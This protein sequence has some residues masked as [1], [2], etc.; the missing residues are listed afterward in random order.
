MKA[1]TRF[2]AALA[3]VCLPAALLATFWGALPTIPAAR[4]QE[5]KTSALSVLDALPAETTLVL[6]LRN[7]GDLK[8]K[9][10]ASPLNTVKEHPDVKRFLDDLR[11]KLEEGLAEARAKLGFDPLDLADLVQGEVILALGGLDKIAST[12][13]AE[14]SG[15]QSDFTPADVPFLMTVDAG[16]RADALRERL[17][18]VYEFAKQEGAK[19]EVDDFRGGKL[20]TLTTA[21]KEKKEGKDGG[22]DK[23]SL[24]KLYFGDLGSR[25]FMS[26]NRP[27]LEKTMA[28]LSGAGAD[29]LSKG[30]EFAAT[31]KEVK[32]DSD[33]LVFLNIRPIMETIR[34]NV[35]V[36]PIAS[37]VWGMVEGKLLGRSLNN[38]G[39]SF[40]LR[41]GTIDQASFIHN[42]GASDGVLG[43]FKGPTIPGKPSALVPEDV[44]YF[45]SVALNVP[46]LYAFV[47]DV[48]NQVLSFQMMMGGGGNPPGQ[49][50]PNAEQFLEAQLGVKIK[51][52]VD[53]LGS[54]LHFYQ[55]GGTVSLDN[56]V[57]SLTVALEL[58]DEMPIKELLTKL[59]VM[60]GLTSQ[61]YLDRDLYVMG[62]GGAGGAGD[63]PGPA[64]GIGDK[65]L[66]FGVKTDS[67]KEVIRRAGKGGKGVAENP[68]YQSLANRVPRE[69]NSLSYSSAKSYQDMLKQ[70]KDAMAKSGEEL[71]LPD[72]SILSDILAGSIGYGLW[73]D[74]GLYSES[75]IQLKKARGLAAE[76]AASEKPASEKS[77]K[78]EKK[79]DKKEKDDK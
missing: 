48:A 1:P 37:M 19:K 9:L 44:D 32:A 35:Q 59:S 20:T 53:A 25:V 57:G 56:P 46:A 40:S 3:S 28:N 17:D 47:K 68:A 33:L 6:R 75:V 60:A 39:V 69:V 52:V 14:F 16:T 34:K 54:G 78:A 10:K 42:G 21:N 5:A 61:K 31:L 51:P 70:L 43:I 74:Q 58:K 55:K 41:E 65:L 71:P 15:G 7:L 73:K 29:T 72:L 18:K 63:S 4:A 2:P 66:V 30:S 45:V 26:I 13:A 49:E 11:R 62:F 77:E 64:V 12:L 22:G 24:E 79:E 23:G 67:V 50:P 8:E 38:V 36:N 27:F 76:K